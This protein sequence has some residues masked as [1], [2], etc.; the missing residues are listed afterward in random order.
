M[1]VVKEEQ[2]GAWQ[3]LEVTSDY[4]RLSYSAYDR[5][6]YILLF[7]QSTGYLVLISGEADMVTLEHI[8]HEIEIRES[9]LPKSEH[10]DNSLISMIDLARG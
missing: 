5:A 8:A 1:T 3:I 2:L 9:S 4:S 6:N 10:N 7:D